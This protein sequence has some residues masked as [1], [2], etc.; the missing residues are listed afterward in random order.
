MKG[1]MSGLLI[2]RAHRAQGKFPPPAEPGD[3][4]VSGGDGPGWPA[5]LPGIASGGGRTGNGPGCPIGGIG[6][7]VGPGRPG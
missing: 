2:P 4:P 5:G 1:A 3:A 7:L 6:K